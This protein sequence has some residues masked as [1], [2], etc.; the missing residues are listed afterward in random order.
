MTMAYITQIFNKASIQQAA[1]CTDRQDTF[2]ISGAPFALGAETALAPQNGGAYHLFAPIICRLHAGIINKR[3]QILPQII[4]AAALSGQ[5]LAAVGSLFQQRF[6]ALHQR[7]HT[8]LKRL[9]Q[10]GAVPYP[11]P[12]MQNLLSQYRQFASDTAHLSLD[13]RQRLKI[14]FQMCPA[15]LS[16]SRKAII[17]APAVAVKNPGKCAQQLLG[18][19]FSA[20]DLNHKDRRC[21]T[22]HHPQPAFKPVASGPASFIGMSG[23]LRLNMAGYF[24]IRLFQGVG[25]LR[26]TMA[27]AA[28]THRNGKDL[29]HHRQRLAFTGVEI[30]GKN[31][32]HRHDTRTKVLTFDLI[33]QRTMNLGSAVSAS[34]YGLDIFHNLG[35]D[36]WDIDNLMTHRRLIRLLEMSTAAGASIGL[37]INTFFDKLRWQ[38]RS[39]MRRVTFA[40]T[41]FLASP[42]RQFDRHPGGIGRRRLGR[43][44]RILTQKPL[45]LFDMLFQRFNTLFQF[46]NLVLELFYIGVLVHTVIIGQ[47]DVF[48]KIYVKYPK[49]SERLQT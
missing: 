44:A 21:G 9:P 16:Q 15:Q 35:L 29:A 11:I 4:Y 19:G 40:C 38:Q 39:Q 47:R 7:F 26:F 20:S 37:Q 3:P 27:Q 36:G 24:L 8:V 42:R 2:D 25:Q 6:H 45:E 5:R 23:S 18:L 43:I 1:G 34:E 14:A 12:Q 32:N 13:L 33:G 46:D 31:S 30:S 17:A 41:A 49:S 22:A 28:Q 48:L 10:Q